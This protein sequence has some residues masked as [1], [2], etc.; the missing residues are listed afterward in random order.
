[1]PAQERVSAQQIANALLEWRGNVQ[2]A[3]RSLGIAANS[4]YER[5]DRLGL[6]LEGF[7]NMAQGKPV[8]PITGRE[9]VSVVPGLRSD[10][11]DAQKNRAPIF[12]GSARTAKL[13]GVQATAA[14]DE[15]AV[16]I[17]TSPR[18]Q[19]PTRIK[20]AQRERLERAAW[21]LQARYQAPTDANLLLEQ[22]IDEN[23]EAWLASKLA[24]PKSR[25][26]GSAK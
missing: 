11:R 22:F 8:T 13:T 21:T 16:P 10:T 19:T 12:Q 5:I 4:L 7:R 17:K 9:P 25:A 18:R 26:K 6:N 14:D 15:A 3:A 1:M 23:F 2:A 24:A 20:P